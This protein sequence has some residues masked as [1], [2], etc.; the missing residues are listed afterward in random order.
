[1]SS[2]HAIFITAISL[3]LVVLTDLFSDRLKGPITFRNSI[4]S[5]FALGVLN[6]ILPWS[7]GS[8]S[9]CIYLFSDITLSCLYSGFCRLLHHW[10]CND[11]L[12]VSFP[13]WNG[14]CR[15]HINIGICSSKIFVNQTILFYFSKY[16][17]TLL[18]KRKKA[19]C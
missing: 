9:C 10:Y 14:I 1:M 13:W 4:I 8:V 12:A 18:Q 11:L 3:Y 6:P 19:T 16:K 2:A 15:C 7:S 5:T 17:F